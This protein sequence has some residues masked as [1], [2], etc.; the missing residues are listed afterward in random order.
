MLAKFNMANS[1]SQKTPMAQGQKITPEGEVFQRNEV[2]A[3]A[4]GSLMYLSGGTRP[5]ICYAVRELSRHMAKPTI[6]HWEAVKRVLRYLS[7]TVTRGLEYGQDTGLIGY[8]DASY[9]PGGEKSQSGHVFLLHGG[10]IS[11][12]SKRQPT[13]AVSTC[14][15][16][17]M[18]AGSVAREG[19]WLRK[20]MPDLGMPL[21]NKAVLIC[22]DNQ[23]DIAV[24]GNP[25]MHG[26]VKHISVVHHFVRERVQMGQIRFEYV[27]TSENVADTFTKA[28][29]GPGFSAHCKNLGMCD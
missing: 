17:Y 4:V 5:D 15:A 22:C 18:A 14:E 11:W 10:T 24:A 29:G 19:L 1:K 7:G 21:V 8:G 26:R 13:V 6:D 28:L 9:A 25:V 16:E 27:A 20:L 3:S 2:F 23:S 12:D